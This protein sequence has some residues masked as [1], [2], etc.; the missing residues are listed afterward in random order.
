MRTYHFHFEITCASEGHA[1]LE[2][3]EQMIDLS[4][5]ELVFDDEFIKALAEKESVTIQVT[6]S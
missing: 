3:V 4:M 6:Q 1:D 2:R 5:Q